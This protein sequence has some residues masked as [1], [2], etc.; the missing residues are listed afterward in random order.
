[1]LFVRRYRFAVPAMVVTGGYVVT[2][3][4]AAVVTLVGGD[5][6]FLWRLALLSDADEGAAATWLNVLILVLAGG[7]WAWALWQCLRGPIAGKPPEMDRGVRLLRLALYAAAASWLVYAVVP[8]WP[9]WAVVPD[10]LLMLA[11]VVLFHPMVRRN[12]GYVG[13][14]LGAG[15]LVHVSTASVEVFDALDWHQAEQIAEIGGLAG[16]AGLIWQVL[17]L[18]AQWRDGR[19]QRTTVWYGVAYLVA[20]LAFVPLA[21]LGEISREAIWATEALWVIWLARSGHDLASPGDE[22]VPTDLANEQDP[23]IHHL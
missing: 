5:V 23:G 21:I 7:L 8:D 9:W 3:V 18:T 14:A 1:M 20:P 22:D 16:L 15:V 4:V 11:V 2:L 12:V 6:G 19:W 13:L 10:S 17:V